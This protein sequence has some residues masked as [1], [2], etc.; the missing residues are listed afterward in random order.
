MNVRLPVL[1]H[2]FGFALRPGAVDLERTGDQ[3]VVAICIPDVE[4]S[5]DR[6]PRGVD[7]VGVGL[8]RRD[9]D[10]RHGLRR[11]R[12]GPAG[13]RTI[14]SSSV[15]AQPGT[16]NRLRHRLEE[17]QLL[18]VGAL[19]RTRLGA[20]LQVQLL[21]DLIAARIRDLIAELAK[22]TQITPELPLGDTGTL[23]ELQRVQ[24]WLGN[25]RGK[26]VE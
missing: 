23:S 22:L 6:K 17:L 10:D 12:P 8:T 26:D 15:T 14:A 9:Q 21:L 25:D 19:G 18:L 16:A 24:A 5:L 2:L 1:Q 4:A 3:N 7:E 13:F 11:L 20:A